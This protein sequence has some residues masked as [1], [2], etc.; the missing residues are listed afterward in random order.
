M[1]PNDNTTKIETIHRQG[2]RAINEGDT[3]HNLN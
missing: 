1:K 2:T 3:F